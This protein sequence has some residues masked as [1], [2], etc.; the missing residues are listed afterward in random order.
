MTNR[1]VKCS[2][3]RCNWHGTDDE[4]LEAPN[5]FDEND[6]ITGCP[7]CKQV[8]TT[9]YACDEPGCWA[10]VCSGVAT[11]TGYRSTCHEHVPKE[12]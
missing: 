9:V 12:D 8:D 1:K 3:R 6:V 7:K 4:V 11:K 5:P 10:D 2:G